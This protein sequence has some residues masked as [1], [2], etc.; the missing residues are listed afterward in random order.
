M[1]RISKLADYSVVILADLALDKQGLQSASDLAKKTNLAEPTV[2]KVLKMLVKAEIVNSV[3]GANGGYQ[4]CKAPHQIGVSQIIE[5]IDGPI[6]ITACAG[7]VEHDCGLIQS[8]SVRGRW[9]KVNYALLS[10][11]KDVTLADMMGCE[12]NRQKTGSE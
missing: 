11:L 7:E 3:R 2:S 10:A 5:A 9:S 1:I 12:G 6:A 4:L 8:C